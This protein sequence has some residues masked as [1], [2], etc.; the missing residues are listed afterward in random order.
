MAIAT[1]QIDLK[2]IK[3]SINI[4]LSKDSHV[5]AGGTTSALAGATDIV[6]TAYVGDTS[7]PFTIGTITG[8]PN[9]MSKT[10]SAVSGTNNQKVNIAVTTSMNTASGVLVIPVTVNGAIIKK[11]FSF[12]IAFSGTAGR[13]ITSVD[14][15]FAKNTSNSEAPTTG[16]D[17][18]APSWQQGYYI[19]S[20][21]VTTYS[22]GSPTT[23]VPVCITGGVGST[24]KGVDSIT[25]EY[26]I[27][28]S[29]TTAPASGSFSATRP[30]WTK[31]NYIWTRNK[32]VYSNPSSTVYTTPVVSSEW[33][34]ANDVKDY[35]ED[36]IG[37]RGENLLTNGTGLLGDNTNFPGFTF[38][39]SEA[40]GAS[41]SFT[42]TISNTLFTQ[43]L[44]PV[45]PDETYRLTMY[46]KQTK[47]SPE[48]NLNRQYAFVDMYDSDKLQITASHIM[49]VANTLT[50]LAQDLKPGDT[51]VYLTN[52]SNWKNNV[53]TATHQRG[54]IFWHY[55]NSGGYEYPE[56][57]YSRYVTHAKWLDGAV[58]YTNNTI[59]LSSPWNYNNPKDP[60]GIW[61]AG[62]KLSNSD[63][64]GT[65]AYNG[66]TGH[67]VPEVWTKY[68]GTVSGTDLSGRNNSSK[69]RPG[70]AFVKIGWL[71][72]YGG[73]QTSGT[74][75]TNNK[76]YLSN[77]SFNKDV[78]SQVDLNRAIQTA[79]IEY[80][81]STSPT[82]LAGGS[83]STTAPALTSAQYLWSR[84][85]VIYM[86]GTPEYRPSATGTNISGAQ[87]VDGNSITGVTE[88]Y[89][90]STSSTSLSGDTWGTEVPTWENGRYIWTRTKITYSKTDPYTTDPICVSGASGINAK[91]ISFSGSGQTFIKNTS[92]SITPATLTAT[93][94]V[95]NTTIS[96]W[97]YSVDGDTFS[98]SV[99]AGVARS[100]NTVTVT[101]STMTAKSIVIKASDGT[102]SDVYTVTKVE[103]GGNALVPVLSNSSHTVPASY[104]GVVSSY[105][106]SGTT[107]QVLEGATPLTFHTTLANGRFTIGTPVISPALKITVGA[108]SGSGTNTATVAVH[109]GMDANTDSVTI[110]YPITAK[111]S[112]GTQATFNV[113]QTITKSKEGKDGPDGYTVILTNESHTFPGLE[114]KA[115]PA[116]SVTSSIIV[117][118]GSTQIPTSV[119]VTG[120]PGGMNISISGNVSTSNSFT[121]T[122]D[123]NTDMTTMNGELTVTITADGKTFPK[124]FS[125]A[126][127]KKGTDGTPGS[128]G[129]PAKIVKIVP[130][131]LYFIT[132]TVSS[133]PSTYVYAPSSIALTPTF[134]SCTYSK[135]KYST[136]GST[137]TD[138]TTQNGLSVNSTSKVLTVSSSSTLFSTTQ[139]FLIFK[140]ESS[141]GEA[142]V[143]TLNRIFESGALGS[144]LT[145]AE[146][147]ITQ[148][149][150]QIA[151]KVTQTEVDNSIKNIQVGGR[152]LA[153]G[154][155]DPN[156]L[157]TYKVIATKTTVDDS[158]S[159]S[160]KTLEFAISSM[161]TSNSNNDVFYITTA[162][163][164]GSRLINGEEYTYSFMAKASQP[165]R[166][167]ARGIN[168]AVFTP[169]TFAL[170]TQYQLISFQF[171]PTVD[172]GTAS[173][174]N[175]HFTLPD[176]DGAGVTLFVQPIKIEKGNMATDWTPA[177]EDDKNYIDKSTY[178][179][180][181]YIRDWENGSSSNTGNHWYEIQAYADGVNV[182]L[183]KPAST[184]GTISGG[185]YL[186]DGITS[187]G[188]M[189]A[190]SDLLAYAQVDLGQV[191]YNIQSIKVWRYHND[192]RTYHET[193]TE[194]SPDGIT[195]YTVFDSY[196]EG[197]YAE[198]AAGKEFPNTWARHESLTGTRSVATRISSAEQKITP[199]AIT[200]TVTQSTTYKNDLS[201]KNKV[202]TSQPTPPY[203]VGDLWVQGSGGDAMRCKTARA[204]GS[205]TA[206]DWEK[207]VKYTDDSASEPRWI[208]SS[209]EPSNPVNGMIWLDTT[210]EPYT[211][212]QWLDG[213][214]IVFV[215]T[216]PSDIGA[217]SDTDAQALIGRVTSAEQSITSDNITSTVTENQIFLDKLSGFLTDEQIGTKI[218]Q[219]L[220]SVTTSVTTL[221]KTIDGDPDIPGDTGLAGELQTVRTYMTFDTNGLLLGKSNSPL[222]ISIDN[223]E[224]Q[225]LNAGAKIAWITGQEMNI[226]K[227]TVT[228]SIKI[229]VHEIYKYNNDITVIKWVG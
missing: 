126:V 22:T 5:F 23:S 57:F 77:L 99:P 56:E 181:R 227:V 209:T 157:N 88:E 165:I 7:V 119:A 27:S 30:V 48:K 58:N 29:K 229:G 130:S 148:H 98:S 198:T 45:N 123:S 204:T 75:A 83:W 217:F 147:N 136:N 32:I 9:G 64:G 194:V 63:S 174:H 228:S 170:T 173:N 38:D 17:T 168:Q 146:S 2:N 25:E 86:D 73:G 134:Q 87:G 59:T 177:P 202:F 89:Y 93:A 52:A 120:A 41:G 3:E 53:G 68:T 115:V 175:T 226:T 201:S 28:T 154:T 207:A 12:A 156:K 162:D 180:V 54:F 69:F 102:Y 84:T 135:W 95:Q 200:S 199:Q 70:T 71:V 143:V 193:K 132:N 1:G 190:G 74:A 66:M 225:F 197:E 129:T 195:W 94:E 105:T 172:G 152:N 55:K 160:G 37:S 133:D 183:G 153:I 122:I 139:T 90:S 149:A 140:C 222:Q 21:T 216:K 121:A 116:S 184:N 81:A 176:G 163:L 112:N 128:P 51:V 127:A 145:T 50:T 155:Y 218:E 178:L 113:T 206:S 208:K 159:P 72:H 13:S 65:F 43:E 144:R 91:L 221:Q 196:I 167:Q 82:S 85:K 187:G 106:G 76:L 213:E 47:G 110:T 14:V 79:D 186:T 20:R 108:R 109:S 210:E 92:G 16:W 220:E 151:L 4:I 42:Y 205:Y 44:M 97:T 15:E 34:A 137:W 192:G 171:K 138:I 31:G 214:W 49:W 224:M 96:A 8:V 10:V 117:Y 142:D 80:Y 103:D 158:N 215:P 100:G 46:A 19:W 169:Q 35:L 101:G 179:P 11:E 219:N 24:G 118:K 150:D 107:I 141:T 60:E 18:D 164:V 185:T 212:Q 188:Y 124:K 161:G 104:A 33:E 36:Y 62:H 131:A 40:Y 111:R 67:R 166:L 78:A 26:A 211:P 191:F 125:F 61:R 39:T 6:I 203:I 114:D 223:D 182:A 189:G